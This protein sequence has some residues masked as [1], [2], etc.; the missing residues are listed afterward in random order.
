MRFT[1][2]LF[3]SLLAL[4][5]GAPEAIADSG[6]EATVRWGAVVGG[7]DYS[8]FWLITNRYGALSV[9]KN[10]CYARADFRYS[11]ALD[12]WWRF[13]AGIDGIVSQ[14][15]DRTA[16]LQQ[17]YVLLGY[18]SLTLSI[19][20]MERSGGILDPV[21]SSGDMAH[22]TNAAPIPEINLRMEEFQPVP[23]TNRWLRVKGDFAM[24]RSLDANYLERHITAEHRPYNTDILWHHKSLFFQIGREDRF[25]LLCTLGVQHWAE[26]GG[27]S[28]TDPE[29]KQPTGLRDMLRVILGSG[30]GDGSTTSD[31]IN[32]LGNHYGT[33][34]LKL[35]YISSCMNLHLYYQ[36][37]FDDKSGMAFT[38]GLD[39]LWGGEMS[40]PTNPYLP[41]VLLEY[42]TTRSQ[43]GPLHFIE[44]D[45]TKYE[46][47]GGGCDNYYNN[48]EYATGVSY[49][50][51]TLGNPLM[52][53]PAYFGQLGFRH[54]RIRAY[55]VS[56]S[57]KLTRDI[58][59]TGHYS[60]TKSWGTH[61][62]PLMEPVDTHA[63]G[64]RLT[65]DRMDSPWKVEA[66]LG[67]DKGGLL[68]DNIGV[69]IMVRYHI[70]KASSGRRH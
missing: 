55:H 5:F 4:P 40:F 38:N 29:R 42:L 61:E 31:A 32:V 62:L 45:H 58:G 12:N 44:Y 46:G 25:P 13:E 64:I 63:L 20:S 70:L 24:G 50:Q 39:G 43:S 9:N 3:L 41:T 1:S 37:Y 2:F 23:L 16:Y 69:E 47:P 35:S 36:H 51:R 17:L 11:L 22:G 53:S 56:L 68:K 18:R 65:Y 14:G 34:D 7:G 26:W 67:W 49:Y 28:S 27:K 59:Y 30:G 15:T 48:G 6:M 66:G 8:P 52:P 19:G 33:Y 21:L 54:N 10:Q 57:G 60:Y